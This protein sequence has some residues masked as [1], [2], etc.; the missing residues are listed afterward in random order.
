MPALSAEILCEFDLK[1]VEKWSSHKIEKY[2]KLA[3]DCFNFKSLSKCYIC[4][5]T[6]F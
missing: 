6:F 3:F 4:M 5:R 1:E 2:N